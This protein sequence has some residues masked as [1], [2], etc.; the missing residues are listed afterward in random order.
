MKDTILSFHV[1][2]FKGYCGMFLLA[3]ALIYGCGKAE[4]DNPYLGNM[5]DFSYGGQRKTGEILYR[6]NALR[7]MVSVA[8][9]EGSFV[10]ADYAATW[11]KPCVAQAQ[12]IKGLE[13]RFGDQV[14]FLTVMTSASAEFESIPT[15][16]TARAWAQRFGLDPNRVVAANNLWAMRIPTHILYSPEGQT[17]YRFTGYL[18]ADKIRS[19][20][21]QYMKDWEN[22]SEKGLTAAWMRFRE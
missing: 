1:P 7:E 6:V 2:S 21:S 5:S 3:S 16:K 14:V 20:L 10:W 8:D 22:W 18:P 17:L 9:F 12:V 15:A 19:T 13:N 11:C 4:P